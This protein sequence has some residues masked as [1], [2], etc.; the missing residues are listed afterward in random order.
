MPFNIWKKYNNAYTKSQFHQ[1]TVIVL[2]DKRDWL[3][4]FPRQCL[5]FHIKIVLCIKT[6][7]IF[8]KLTT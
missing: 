4:E 1:F 5:T 7:L 6:I 8:D 2:N 3:A